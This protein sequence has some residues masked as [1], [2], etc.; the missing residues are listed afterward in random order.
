MPFGAL[1]MTLQFL[2]EFF[3]TIL[4]IK[5]DTGGLAIREEAEDLGR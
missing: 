5:G 3:K 4:V 1:V 2:G